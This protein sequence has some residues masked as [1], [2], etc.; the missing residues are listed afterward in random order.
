MILHEVFLYLHGFIFVTKRKVPI[1]T[2]GWSNMLLWCQQLLKHIVLTDLINYVKCTKG[3][4]FFKKAHL[5]F[6]KHSKLIS[7]DSWEEKNIDS[8]R[9]KKNWPVLCSVQFAETLSTLINAV[10]QSVFAFVIHEVMSCV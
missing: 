1:F 2:S 5:S 4:L 3:I 7:F 6:Y 9:K 10:Y 8:F